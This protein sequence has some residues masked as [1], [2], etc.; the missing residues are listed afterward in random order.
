MIHLATA[1]S[2]LTAVAVTHHRRH[3]G[4]AIVLLLVIVA[5]GYYLWRR[6]RMGK[7]PRP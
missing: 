4:V 1:M 5:V 6:N 2:A 3:V 7:R